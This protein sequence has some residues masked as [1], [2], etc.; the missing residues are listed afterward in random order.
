MESCNGEWPT[1]IDPFCGG[2][3][4]PLEAQR[5]G[6]P[7]YGGDL[8]PVAVLISKA[9]VEIPPRFAGM[10]PVNP[11]AQQSM[12]VGSWDGAR[13]LAEDIRYY[14]QWMRDRAVE[15]IGHLYPTAQVSE[16]EGKQNETVIA[17]MWARTVRSPDPA[18]DGHVPLVNSWV[19]RRKPKKPV[20]WVEPVVNHTTRTIT[21]RIREGGKPS[22]GNYQAGNWHL[23]SYRN[24]NPQCLSQGEVAWWGNGPNDDSCCHRGP[25]RKEVSIS[26]EFSLSV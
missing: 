3:T 22:S 11:E 6:L 17:W 21:Y 7:A 9:M 10:P 20:I 25:E 16:D 1:V 13:G 23:H 12:S 15:R 8:N 26:P 24:H 18:W 4:I 19:L 2:G 5:L 14:G